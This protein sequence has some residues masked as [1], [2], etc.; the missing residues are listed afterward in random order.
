MLFYK[1]TVET[2][3]NRRLNIGY[4]SE[5]SEYESPISEDEK[6]NIT[7]PSEGHCNRLVLMSVIVPYSH[8]Y[9]TVVHS[10]EKLLSNGMLESEFIKSCVQ[11]ITNK[12]EKFECKYGELTT[13]S[14]TFE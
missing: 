6:A 11:E 14:N 5:D 4:D 8:T 7:L 10:L 12:V 3:Y 1:K 2:L 13:T 9:L